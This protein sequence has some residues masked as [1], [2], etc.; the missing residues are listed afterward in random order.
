MNNIKVTGKCA[1]HIILVA[2]LT[3]FNFR[4]SRQRGQN[5]TPYWKVLVN[6]IL[7]CGLEE[8]TS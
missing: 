2:K 6:W 5:L 1:Y 8:A 3:I 4:G 7:Q